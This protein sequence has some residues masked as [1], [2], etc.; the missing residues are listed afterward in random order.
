MHLTPREQEKLLIY[1]AAQV[2][3]DRK[4][5]GLKLNHPEAVAYLTAEILEGIRDGRSVSELMS[6]GATLL[7][8]KDVMPGVPEM[9]PELQVE[10]TFPDGTKLVTVHQPIR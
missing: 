10:G 5:R 3:K 7:K 9:L 1:V 8:R 6:Y 4:A 2:A